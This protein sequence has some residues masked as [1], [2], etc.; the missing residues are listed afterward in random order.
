MIY[1][2]EEGDI[3]VWVDERFY[4]NPNNELY[5]KE[6]IPVQL[7]QSLRSIIDIFVQKCLKT[8]LSTK[9][10]TRLTEVTCFNKAIEVI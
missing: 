5:Q 10:F 6:I 4:I 1:L 7:S 2:T 3:K 8:K 9:L